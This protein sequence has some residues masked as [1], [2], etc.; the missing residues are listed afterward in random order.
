[1]NE[2][3]RR[4]DIYRRMGWCPVPYAHHPP[5]IKAAIRKLRMRPQMKECFMNCQKFYIFDLTI[6]DEDIIYHEGWI[7]TIIPLQHA[8]LEWKGQIIDLTLNKYE[9]DIKYLKSNTYSRT[10]VRAAVVKH[11]V[12]RPVDDYKMYVIGPYYSIHEQMNK[13][14]EKFHGQEEQTNQRNAK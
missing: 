11:G 5:E 1:M 12:W 10:E 13:T 3:D 6:P 9:K 4:I 8:W 14:M 2:T 7:E